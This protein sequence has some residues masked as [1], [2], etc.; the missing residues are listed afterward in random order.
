MCPQEVVRL[1][2][3]ADEVVAMQIVAEHGIGDEVGRRILCNWKRVTD[4]DF[5][6]MMCLA[7]LFDAARCCRQSCGALV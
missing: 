5:R 7:N 3:A 6:G 2:S 4:V 1:L